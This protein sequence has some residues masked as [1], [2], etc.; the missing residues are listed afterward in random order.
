MAEIWKPV[1]GYEGFYEVSD[2]GRV[3]SVE[4]TVR[5][6]RGNATK[7][8][9]S[10][11]LKQVL[12]KSGYLTVELCKYGI[13]KKKLVHRLVAESFLDNP[14]NLPQVNHKDENKSNNVIDNLEWCSLVYNNNYGTINERRGKSIAKAKCKPVA[15]IKD[16]LVIKVFPSTISARHIA[17]PS[18]IGACALGKR[19]SAGGYLWQY[20]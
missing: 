6:S 18:H 12:L 13:R 14:N 16:G 5:S 11:I 19:L 10:K 2:C 1:S 20:I 7:R 9:P 15:Q 8:S 4:R 17:D 3:R